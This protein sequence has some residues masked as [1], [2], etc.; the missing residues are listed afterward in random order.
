MNTNKKGNNFEK[1][2][3]GALG[4]ALEDGKLG[5]RPENA[6]IFRQ[7]GYYSTKR[8]KDILF[9]IS[10]EVTL[11]GAPSPSF[12]WLWECKDYS[13]SV[14]VG[15]LEEFANKVE[16]VTDLNVKA[17]F[18]TNAPL[19]ESA[20]SFA[21]STGIAVVQI[22]GGAGPEA[23]ALKHICYGVVISLFTHQEDVSASTEKHFQYIDFSNNI[24][25]KGG[26]IKIARFKKILFVDSEDHAEIT[27]RQ[28]KFGGCTIFAENAESAKTI[29][30]NTFTPDGG[31]AFD[32]IVSELRFDGGYASGFDFLE[33][34]KTSPVFSKVRDVIFVIFSASD[35]RAD[36]R[37]GLEL[38]AS[39]YF[40]KPAPSA[41]LIEDWATILQQISQLV[42]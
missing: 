41:Q 2:A 5:I 21:R 28:W 15:D 19:Q 14:P 42:R 27:R 8:G 32:L 31:E 36:L 25:P 16:Q 12:Y 20:M 24:C 10:I 18:I 33:M 13:G 1:R 9:D 29:I 30:K 26:D 4:R 17:G 11:E 39:A 6:V 37:K 38:G 34:I 3:F 23:N 35:N 22:T 40:V 7:K